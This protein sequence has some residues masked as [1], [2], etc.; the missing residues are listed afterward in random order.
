MISGVPKLGAGTRLS[1]YATI[2]SRPRVYSLEIQV[3]LMPDS[4]VALA[5][6]DP[7]FGTLPRGLSISCG[8]LREFPPLPGESDLDRREP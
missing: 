5:G 3:S 7:G 2:T 4:T 8:R 6:F 1:R